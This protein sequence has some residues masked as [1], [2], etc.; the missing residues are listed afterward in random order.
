MTQHDEKIVC[1]STENNQIKLFQ[2]FRQIIQ[3]I[4]LVVVTYDIKL[5]VGKNKL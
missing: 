5:L 3:S 4:G 1:R 2:N